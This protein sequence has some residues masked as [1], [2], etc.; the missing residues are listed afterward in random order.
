MELASEVIERN[1]PIYAKTRDNLLF[2][3][4]LI[5]KKEGSLMQ[6]SKRLISIM[7]LVVCLTLTYLA[8]SSTSALAAGPGPQPG[9]PGPQRPLPPPRPPVHKLYCPPI[10]HFRDRGNDVK[11]LQMALNRQGYRDMYNH[12]LP[13]NGIFGNETLFAL[14]NFQAR[15]RMKVDGIAGPAVW[16]LLGQCAIR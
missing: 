13:L 7:T 8:F 5:V 14:K 11:N 3:V 15:H 10:H 12:P 1:I 16:Q 6:H 2:F 4:P 9:A